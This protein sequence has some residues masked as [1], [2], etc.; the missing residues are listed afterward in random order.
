MVDYT[1]SFSAPYYFSSFQPNIFEG[2]IIIYVDYKGIYLSFF[3]HPTYWAHNTISY[4]CILKA[5]HLGT[6]ES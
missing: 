4:H 1:L 2:L 5:P 6:F 3:L